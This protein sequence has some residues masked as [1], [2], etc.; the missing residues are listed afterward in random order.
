MEEV[1]GHGD[2]EQ[3]GREMK[4]GEGEVQPEVGTQMEEVQGHGDGEQVGREMEEGEGEV[5]VEVGTQME[6]VQGHGD[7]EQV[8]RKMEEGEGEVQPEVDVEVHSE[9]AKQVENGDDG[10]VHD[11]EEEEV[12][13]AEEV[14]VHDFELQN[15]G[16]G[17]GDDADDEDEDV[18]DG[19]YENV[20]DS[21]SEESL[22][23]VR[24]ECDIETSKGQPC[25]LE[26]ECSRRTE[27]DS[28]HD[29]H[30][31]FDIEWVSDELD[32][33]PDSENDDASIPKTLFPH[34][35]CLKVWGNI[36]GK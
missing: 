19:E 29:V 4:E 25:S 17:V 24:V 21:I 13:D 18:D 31:L 32:S 8:D 34:L 36:N 3:V 10:E 22:V 26:G 15:G 33:G 35:L 27:N 5:Q 14:E 1:Q 23:D 11:V 16:H 6:E 20:E 7:G 9:V 28:M 2:G 30:G 12:H